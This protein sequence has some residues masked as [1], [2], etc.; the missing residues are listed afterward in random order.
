MPVS[1]GAIVFGVALLLLLILLMIYA[2]GVGRR[3]HQPVEPV[4]TGNPSM[5]RKVAVILGLMLASG[6]SLIGYSFYEP[7]RQARAADRQENVSIER[8]IETYTTNC[9]GCHGTTGLGAVVPDSNP[10]RVAPTLNRADLRPQDPDEYRQRYDFV[11]KT[12]QRGRPG[13]PMPAWGRTDGGTLLDEQLHELTLMI[14]K[15]D[16]HIE[17]EESVWDVV[18]VE[19]REK[20]AHGS[21]EPV[22]PDLALAEN[23]TG[24]CAAGQNLWKGKAACIG[25]H[26]IG[27]VGGQTGPNLSQIGSVAGTRQ[28]GVS[29]EEYI[30][31]S[32]RSPAGYL[33]PGY[34]NVMPAYPEST[35]TEQELNQLVSYY[36][37]LTGQ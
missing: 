22:A 14:T 36:L 37:S 9:M 10:P 1:A 35:L 31:T 2:S 28:P 30:R 5:E 19:A 24:D 12:L 18:A 25:C 7:T 6:L 29:A 8:A 20:I 26:L 23:C 21:P 15:G 17:G 4:P 34:P 32:I 11:Y 13:T 27:G 3:A 33:V 16:K